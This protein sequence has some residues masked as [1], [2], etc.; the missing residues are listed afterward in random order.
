MKLFLTILI[1]S[2]IAGFMLPWWFMA[3]IAFLAAIIMGKKAGNSFGM[4]FLAVAT[5]W[6]LLTL[7]KTLPNDNMLATRVATLVH[8]PGWAFLLLVTAII[9]GLVGGLAG[10]SGALLKA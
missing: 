5:A 7:I 10:M 6:I 4:S 8:L 9:G 1:L 3:V 2:F